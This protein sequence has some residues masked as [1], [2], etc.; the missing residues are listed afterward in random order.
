MLPLEG[1]IRRAQ[2]GPKPLEYPSR[3]GHQ[4]T[5]CETTL[6]MYGGQGSWAPRADGIKEWSGQWGILASGFGV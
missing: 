4:R 5:P 1:D 6:K 2:V 3:L